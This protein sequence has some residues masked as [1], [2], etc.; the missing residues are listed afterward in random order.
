MSGQGEEG[1][2]VSI[3][4]FSITQLE[5]PDDGEDKISFCLSV[6]ACSLNNGCSY[7]NRVF[8]SWNEIPSYLL[9]CS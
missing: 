2:I 8:M 4:L 5:V 9:Y 3:F 6:P 7:D 1:W